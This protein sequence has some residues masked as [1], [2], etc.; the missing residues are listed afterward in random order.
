MLKEIT[1]EIIA[2]IIV[3]LLGV[4]N[5]YLLNLL[6][7]KK[8]RQKKIYLRNKSLVKYKVAVTAFEMPNNRP[9]TGYGELIALANI[10]RSIGLSF[11]KKEISEL[12]D[13]VY[14]STANSF[15][16]KEYF[17]DLIIIGGATHNKVT[18]KFKDES[19][20]L[21]RIVANDEYNDIT[22]NEDF[23]FLDKIRNHKYKSAITTSPEYKITNDFGLITKIY[24]P[25]N[26]EKTII[27]V[28]GLHTFG[29]V[30][31]SQFFLPENIHKFYN[32]V[33]KLEDD[34]FQI[35]IET[36]V[37]DLQVDIKSIDY[38]PLSI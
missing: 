27:I 14:L 37:I 2:T 8:R 35:L 16:S 21:L 33:N 26:K 23:Y 7:F 6:I 10:N 3:A 31:A 19:D 36:R 30:A 17:N 13:K 18:K 11:S 28:D 22:R 29:L 5:V 12:V 4:L 24:N 15:H 1:Y 32:K 34:Y 38:F 9:R 25:F 20:N